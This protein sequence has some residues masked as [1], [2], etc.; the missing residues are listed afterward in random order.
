MQTTTLKLVVSAP[1]SDLTVPDTGQFTGVSSGLGGISDT[2][3]PAVIILPIAMVIV[4]M[5]VV[6]LIRYK[7]KSNLDF[8]I[9]RKKSIMAFRLFLFLI[10]GV[11]LAGVGKMLSSE[12]G[13]VEATTGDSVSFSTTNVVTIEAQLDEDEPV[14]ACGSGSVS[15][16]QALPAGYS[17]SMSASE[18]KLK[19]SDSIMIPYAQEVGLVE[20]SWGYATGTGVTIDGVKPISATPVKIN[21]INEATGNHNATD[22]T[23]CV[24]LSPDAEIGTYESTISYSVIPYTVQYTLNYNA[25]GG[26]FTTP[27]EAQ[28]SEETF[29]NSYGFTVTDIEPVA[30]AETAPNFYGWSITG[31][32]LSD[33]YNAGETIEVD[34]IDTTLKAVWGYNKYTIT[35]NKNTEEEVQNFVPTQ[36]CVITERDGTSCRVKITDRV[37][38][39]SGYTL[40]GWSK[41]AFVPGEDTTL[42]QAR[43]KVDFLPGTETELNEDTNLYAIWWAV[44]ANDF[45]IEL[46]WGELPKD[47]DS[48]LVAIKNSDGSE[49]FEVYFLNKEEEINNGTITLSSNLDID[50]T[51]S[52]GPETLT[53]NMVPASAY[54]DYTFY[55]YIHKFSSEEG[56]SLKASGANITLIKAGGDVSEYAV[57]TAAGTSADYWNVFAIKNGQVVVRNTLTSTPE[58]NY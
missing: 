26:T 16:D 4:A 20:N 35:Y 29:A 6:A 18:M 40:L 15:V 57:S 23:F 25:N 1:D 43:A 34:T 50:D 28:V 31:D 41:E 58:L 47:L 42:D 13:Q 39:I 54:S 9:T 14:V 44:S 32:S 46:R 45:Q 38:T 30:S 8:T 49:V 56:S 12:N 7:R 11:A 37:P 19:E 3:N 51:D 27:P 36:Y 22:V 33:I 53:L 52:N 24:M 21:D 10:I 48:H 55:Y 17:L 2:F 5:I